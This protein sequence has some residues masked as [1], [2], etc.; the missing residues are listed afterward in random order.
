[1]DK[2]FRAKLDIGECLSHSRNS[3][4]YRASGFDSSTGQSRQFVV[5]RIDSAHRE[6]RWRNLRLRHEFE[7]LNKINSDHVIKAF[8]IIST[9]QGLGLVLEDF[10]GI[11]L[12]EYVQRFSPDIETALRLAINL[13]EGVERIHQARIIHKDLTPS[14]ILVHPETLALRIIDFGISCELGK[15]SQEVSAQ[16]VL[17][18]T[19]PYMS[20]EQTGRINRDLDYRT[21]FYTVG[22][23][24]YY[25]FAGSPPFNAEDDIG[26]IHAHIAEIPQRLDRLLPEFP[27]TLANIVQKLLAKEADQRYQSSY[28]LLYDLKSCLTYSVEQGRIPAFEIA[29]HDVS[30]R[31]IIPQ[32]LIGREAEMKQMFEI[33]EAICQ[34]ENALLMV[35]GY[36]GV[37]KSRLIGEVNFPV[38]KS[39]GLFIKGKFDQLNLN[40]PYSAFSQALDRLATFILSL[41][42]SQFRQWQSKIKKTLDINAGVITGLA[43]RF[44]QIIPDVPPLTDLNPG[45]S[46]NRLKGVLVDFFQLIANE[47][48]PLV[49]FLDDMQWADSATLNFL[50]FIAS[51]QDLSHILLICAYRDNE[52][53][54]GHPFIQTTEKI[55]QDIRLERMSL[56]PLSK[57]SVTELIAETL[58]QSNEHIEELAGIVFHKAEG[59]P[60][61]T[62]ELLDGLF[63]Q[64]LIFFDHQSGQWSSDL[65][66]IRQFQAA[67]NVIKFM[68]ERLDRLSNE[69]LQALKIASCIGSSFELT[70]LAE[71]LAKSTFHLSQILESAVKSGILI[72]LTD[73]YRFSRLCEVNDREI[74]VVYRFQHDKVQQAAY[75]LIPVEEKHLTHLQIARMLCRDGKYQASFLELARHYNTAYHLLSEDAE[76]KQLIMINLEAARKVKSSAAYEQ[77]DEYL[78]IAHEL[79]NMRKGIFKNEPDVVYD[80]IY[81]IVDTKFFIGDV[82]AAERES[83]QLIN[84]SPN[85]LAKAKVFYLRALH[86]ENLFEQNKGLAACFEGLKL[87]GVR[88]QRQPSHIK[89][90]WEVLRFY[91]KIRRLK[92]FSLPDRP[93]LTDPA[94]ILEIRFYFSVIL[95]SYFQNNVNMAVYCILRLL[96][97]SFRHGKSPESPYIYAGAAMLS[98]F[99][100]QNKISRQFYKLAEQS[101]DESA[102]P[103]WSARSHYVLVTTCY[104]WH[105]DW[106]NSLNNFELL[107]EKSRKAGDSV[108]TAIAWYM[109]SFERAARDVNDAISFIEYK[110]PYLEK[111]NNYEYLIS[112]RVHQAFLKNLV[113]GEENP[114]LRLDIPEMSEEEVL[115]NLKTDTNLA[116]FHLHKLMLYI[117]HQEPKKAYIQYT[118]LQK[119]YDA[120]RLTMI[121]FGIVFFGSLAQADY[122]PKASWLDKLRIRASLRKNYRTIC[123]WA[124]HNPNGFSHTKDI[125]EAEMARVR[126][127]PWL[128]I[129]ELYD[130][131]LVNLD[132]ISVEQQSLV[133]L[134]A[135]KHAA[136]FNNPKI[137]AG[138]FFD[139]VAAWE[140]RGATKIAADLQERYQPMLK[141]YLAS[142]SIMAGP[143][144]TTKYSTRTRFSWSITDGQSADQE[145]D[146]NTVIKIAQSLSSEVNLQEL[147]RKLLLTV[148]ES[149]GATSGSFILKDSNSELFYIETRISHMSKNP[150]AV[151]IPIDQSDDVLLDELQYVIRTRQSKIIGDLQNEKSLPELSDRAMTARCV[152]IVPVAH[153]GQVEG[154]LYLENRNIANAFTYERT[155]MLELIAA[156]AAVSIRNAELYRNLEAQVKE[157]TKDIQAI[158]RNI[159]QGILTFKTRDLLIEGN[160]SLHLETILGRS[161]L[162]GLNVFDTL[163][164]GS[165]ISSTAVHDLKTMLTDNLNKWTSDKLINEIVVEDETIGKKVLTL[166]W[167][168]ILNDADQIERIM[169]TVR[170]VTELRALQDREK[171]A[172]EAVQRALLPDTSTLEL[173]EVSSYYRAAESTGGDWFGCYE[174]LAKERL[175]VFIGDVT[176]HGVPSALVTGA[177]AGAIKTAVESV[178]GTDYEPADFLQD[179]AQKANQVV[180]GTG[181]HAG[182]MMTTAF[183]CLDLRN[184]ITSYLNAGHN[185]WLHLTKEKNRSRIVGGTPLG[186]D[187]APSFAVKEFD[188]QPGDLIFAFTDGLIENQGPDGKVLALRQLH[189]HLSAESS[190]HEMVSRVAAMGH[191]V[192]RTTPAEDDCTFLAIKIPARRVGQQSA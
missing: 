18:G 43:P 23:T 29:R 158:L 17:E 155:A 71:I 185:C 5:K 6:D 97:L 143:E 50:R 51:R 135:V 111:I 112:I 103:F 176:G 42:E 124:A 85:N 52:V 88:L 116:T 126:N 145:L 10:G 72:P 40:V 159:S 152:L 169:V 109:Q 66:R 56:Q 3:S 22:A 130:K 120:A 131:A 172:A 146:L 8:D 173:A 35:G 148:I 61:F 67:D 80:L 165:T 90:A 98:L 127:R 157:R 49:L 170:D 94:K 136:K 92:I 139:A 28:G 167:D 121:E 164:N 46:Q 171:E 138:Y 105:F 48:H 191:E 181:Q 141:D 123:R 58:H 151:H 33:Y 39:N 74:N 96:A 106:L 162:T 78:R 91:L 77:A 178:L 183:F 11:S 189:K 1:L 144:A 117:F 160:Y 7:L 75:S 36:S 190:A 32:T 82:E 37:G 147:L 100:R 9:P 107:E 161:R 89:L 101:I 84:V 188:F 30:Q 53:D 19:L 163:F 129:L 177:V 2:H 115:Q 79:Y 27:L 54:P 186:M 55:S 83:A 45:E 179:L 153:L 122:Y 156:Q 16:G 142:G 57:D 69:A 21:D 15:E 93:D 13:V 133:K 25:L 150:E 4:I 168:Y 47:D 44:E 99:L 132:H 60:F 102:D 59:N 114:D 20:P 140:N 63:Q 166:N 128:E 76:I 12:D 174:D 68:I 81:E 118:K 187:A 192:W 70:E 95:Y 134:L 62:R 64:E 137:L 38:I 34:G 65:A 125:L 175:F 154:V 108:S 41:P 14:N 184:G 180:L 87:L 110:I 86:Y 31:F 104:F 24:L 113:L 26:L 73:N 119:F 182:R 149:A